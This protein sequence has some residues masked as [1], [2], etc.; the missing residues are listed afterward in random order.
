M[1]TRTNRKAAV[2]DADEE[3]KSADDHESV[4]VHEPAPPE[5]ELTDVHPDVP[6]ENGA[7]PDIDIATVE[8]QVEQPNTDGEPASN[9]TE[10]EDS[11]DALA[12]QL[13]Q[14]VH[15]VSVVEELSRRAREAARTDLALYEALHA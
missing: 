4:T 6:V 3:Q 10:S 1:S 5:P 8:I 15:S 13:E 2:L 11:A 12:Q 14:L 9:T 7:P